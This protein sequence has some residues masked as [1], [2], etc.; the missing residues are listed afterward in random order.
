MLIANLGLFVTLIAWGSTAPVIFELLKDWDPISFVAARFLLTATIFTV[1]LWIS[2][3]RFMGRGGVIP[4]RH[5][6]ILSAILALFSVLLTVAI[7]YS[8]PINIA[9]IGA[10][11]P[12][13]ASLIDRFLTGRTPPKPVMLALPFAVLG[14][15][16]ADVDLK[17]MMAGGDIFHF[18]GGEIIMVGCVFLWPLYSALLQKWFDGMSQLRRTTLTFT[19]ATPMVVSVATVLLLGGWETLPAEVPDARGWG[20]FLW[21]CIATSILGTFIWNVCVGRIGIVI[22]TMFMN[23]VPA[24][25]I[26]ISMMFGLEPRIEQVIGCVVVVLAVAQAQIRLHFAKRKGSG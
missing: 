8:N 14:G 24:V 25:T 2:E 6:L 11:S 17:S 1:W 10:A 7:N 19:M 22:A 21:T 12:V 5:V 16:L 13:S 3:G 20:L 9:V 23:L 18:Q 26:V 4:W 15:V